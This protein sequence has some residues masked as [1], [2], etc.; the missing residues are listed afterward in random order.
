MLRQLISS[1]LSYLLVCLLSVGAGLARAADT[2]PVASGQALPETSIP[3]ARKG[4]IINW[5]VEDE[6]TLLLQDR[7]GSWYR[8][9]L[10]TP[11][12]YL[13]FTSSLSFATGPSGTLE[14]LDSVIVRGQKFP[15]VSLTRIDPPDLKK[16]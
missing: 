9:K 14:A 2:L 3:F 15:I 11:S 8:A 5:V 6:S 7:Q 13:A 16:K 12:T 4:S 1:F 10:L